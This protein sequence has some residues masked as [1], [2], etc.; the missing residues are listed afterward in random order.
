MLK[1]LSSFVVLFVTLEGI[2]EIVVTIL[3]LFKKLLF[4]SL[5]LSLLVSL[6]QV[7]R[8]ALGSQFIWGD[9]CLVL[10]ESFPS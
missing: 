7:V 1:S 3:T 10:P 4:V 8:I 9:E 6:P 2:T 5:A